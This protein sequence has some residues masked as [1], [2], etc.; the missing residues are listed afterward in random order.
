MKKPSLLRRRKGFSLV[1]V[2]LS[3]GVLSLAILTLVGLVGATFLQVENIVR[4]NRA[5]SVV[6]AFDAVLQ[7]PTLI[8]GKGVPNASKEKV[9]KFD[10]IYDLFQ[11]VVGAEVETFFYL[12]TEL[13]KQGDSGVTLKTHGSL[14]IRDTTL[15]REKYNELHGVGPVF[16]IQVRL[17]EQQLKGQRISLDK[18]TALP[19]DSEYNGGALG[20]TPDLYAP[21]YLPLFVEVFPHSF[22]NAAKT[23]QTERAILSQN[24]IYQR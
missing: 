4:T 2:I 16:R 8:A 13:E 17:A 7:T 6:G 24:I 19:L 12:N 23:G 21:A 15:S 22:S 11:K 5:L 9:A 14:I 20:I 18:E 3:I 1:E 10:I